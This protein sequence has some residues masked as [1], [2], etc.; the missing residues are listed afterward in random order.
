M[1]LRLI[2]HVPFIRHDDMSFESQG[3]PSKLESEHFRDGTQHDR[4][5]RHMG[6]QLSHQGRCQSKEFE[7]SDGEHIP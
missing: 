1:P 6:W 2:R 7:S 3:H 4:E 5:T